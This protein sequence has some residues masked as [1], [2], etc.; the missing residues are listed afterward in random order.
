MK[1]K[2]YLFEKKKY[3][4]NKNE[5]KYNNDNN[6]ILKDENVTLR[7]LRNDKSDY[8]LL[9]KWYQ[10]KEIYSYFEQRILTYDEIVNKYYPRTKPSAKI[11][12]YMIEY[13][14][15]PIG[16]VQYHKIDKESKELYDIYDDD[17]YEV[18]I[19]IGELKNHNKGI[20]KKAIK[21]IC[22]YL[23]N[24]INAKIIVMCPLKNNNKAI[25]CYKKAGFEILKCYKT[26]D[27]IGN[28]QEFVL[29][30]RNNK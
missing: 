15:T 26:E 10:Q 18:D 25:N 9:F 4:I 30:A 19:F 13:N 3:Y 28:L 7:L 1:D 14:D 2:Y 27:T 21:L 29:M 11:P 23:I 22:N 20:G 17:S 6:Y 5:K 12:V 16:I 24:K 8:E